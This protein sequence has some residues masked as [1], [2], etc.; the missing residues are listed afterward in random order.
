RRTGRLAL[1]SGRRGAKPAGGMWGVDPTSARLSVFQGDD[2][3]RWVRSAASFA[4]LEYEQPWPGV[5]LVLSFEQR[6]PKYSLFLDAGVEPKAIVICCKGAE[7]IEQTAS[8]EL[9]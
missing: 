8:D 7:T 9:A 3:A 2:P 5:R 6:I 4:R 1:R